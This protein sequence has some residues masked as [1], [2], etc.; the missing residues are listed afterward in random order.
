MDQTLA[1]LEKFLTKN[2]LT[3]KIAAN[4]ASKDKFATDG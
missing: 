2:E 4:F 1:H 3:H